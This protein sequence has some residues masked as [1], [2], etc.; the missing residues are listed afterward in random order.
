MAKKR[1]GRALPEDRL[2][3]AIWGGV[4]IVIGLAGFAATDG[5]NVH[6]I[7][8]I[9]FGVP[10]GTGVIVVFLAVL[11]YLIDSYTI[12]A[13]S[14]L[15]AN[16]VLRS[17]FGAA[18]PLFTSYMYDSLGIHWA[19]ALPGFVALACIPFIVIFWKY[20]AKIRA[21][22]K[23]SA[24]AERQMNAIIAARMA[25][26]QAAKDEES[27]IERT[28]NGSNA[29]A[30]GPSAVPSATPTINGETEPKQIEVQPA[31]RFGGRGH[32][33]ELSGA[34]KEEYI[35]Y[36]ALADRDEVDLRDDER[37]RLAELHE[38]FNYAKAKQ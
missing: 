30:M 16:S 18:F 10:F 26:M 34:A 5:P 9:I 20:G 21:K 28:R 17:L 25:A 12:Y 3:P 19:A 32:V 15:A 35:M 2:P 13:A 4:L 8:P 33:E 37:V 24:D 1:G 6:W 29:T 22:C 36:E 31:E 27:S 7:A 38:K 23:Y 11:G 14:V